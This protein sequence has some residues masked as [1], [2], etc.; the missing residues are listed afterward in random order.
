MIFTKLKSQFAKLNLFKCW[1]FNHHNQLSRNY[2]SINNAN[3]NIRKQD[4]R[5]Y[6][7]SNRKEIKM[8]T[9]KLNKIDFEFLQRF[10]K[11]PLKN[12]TQLQIKSALTFSMNHTADLMS[13][14]NFL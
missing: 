9:I 4:Q 11:L 13:D 7:N 12:Q 6:K 10:K 8:K 2:R 1:R 14:K 3:G 5:I